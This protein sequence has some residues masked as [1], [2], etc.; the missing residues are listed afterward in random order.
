MSPARA[1]LLLLIAGAIWG[2]GFVAQSTAMASIAPLVFLGLRFLLATL[3]MLPLALRETRQAQKPLTSSD[4]FFFLLIGLFLFGGITAQLFGIMATSVTNA[5]FLTGLYV[6][7]VPFADV[8]L[9]R[10]WPHPV[11][12]PSSLAALIGIWLLSGARFDSFLAPGDWMVILGATFWAL[13]VL[14]I[15]RYASRT[16]R[17]FTLSLVQFAVCAVLGLSW[18]VA[19]EGIDWPAIMAAAPQILYTGIFASCVAIT[20]QTVGLR[21]TAAP[22]A[23]I[24]LSSETLFAALFGAI[25]LGD[26]LPLIG[27]A[28]CA[29][30]FAAM[31]AVELVPM[32]GKR[33]ITP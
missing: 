1:N 16:G 13:Q 29:L 21:Y 10:N 30:I 17:P 18:G 14:F 2:F 12:W 25:L 27:M 32:M 3:L 23:A 31:L 9:F 26:R 19:L 4:R 28:G 15:S 33:K 11:V 6:L 22:Q 5:G 24:F 20:L 7:F 8:I